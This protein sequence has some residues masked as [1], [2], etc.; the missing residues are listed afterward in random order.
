MTHFDLLSRVADQQ[1]QFYSTLR[2]ER[3]IMAAERLGL[4]ADIDRLHL[5]L[6]AIGQA[7]LNS[8]DLLLGRL[9]QVIAELGHPP[10]AIEGEAARR[11][12]QLSKVMRLKGSS[13]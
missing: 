6:E 2:R 13:Q 7:R 4:E 11:P 10:P 12:D 8:L 9:D 3:E 1:K 5:E